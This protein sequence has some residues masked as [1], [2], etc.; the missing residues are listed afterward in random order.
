MALEL[1][2]RGGVFENSPQTL[3][4]DASPAAASA[5]LDEQLVQSCRNSKLVSSQKEAFLASASAASAASSK[6]SASLAF[7]VS[8]S[9]YS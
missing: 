1:D 9:K 3:D 7:L 6:V 5:S 2:P 4:G 8:F